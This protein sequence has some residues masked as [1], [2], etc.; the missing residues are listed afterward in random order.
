MRGLSGRVRHVYAYSMMMIRSLVT[1]F[2]FNDPATTEIYTY[3]HTLSLHDALPISA[4]P[5]KYAVDNQT[6]L[7]RTASAPPARR[8]NRQ[9]TPQNA[10][11]RLAQITSAQSRLQK[12]ALN[13]YPRAASTNSST[14]PSVCRLRLCS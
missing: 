3:L 13:Q 14:P 2:F 1:Y 4:E 12:E 9:Q 7:L 10:P 11:F 5:P 8:V 6:V